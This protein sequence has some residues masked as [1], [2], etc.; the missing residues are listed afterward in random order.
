MWPLEEFSLQQYRGKYLGN[1]TV[2]NYLP[3][4]RDKVIC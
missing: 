3:E 1:R 2:V 4:D